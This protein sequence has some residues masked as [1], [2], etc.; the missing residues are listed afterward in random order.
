[1]SGIG[2]K[3]TRGESDT[4]RL[5]RRWRKRFETAAVIFKNNKRSKSRRPQVE[6]VKLTEVTENVTFNALLHYNIM[7]INVNM[8]IFTVKEVLQRNI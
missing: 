7:T 3:E 1:M 5:H 6:G 2:K 4:E 8:F